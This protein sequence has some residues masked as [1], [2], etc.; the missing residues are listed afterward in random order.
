MLTVIG[1]LHL[2]PAADVD[3]PAH[4]AG[5][6]DE[7]RSASP[8]PAPGARG[9]RRS[10]EAEERV[11]VAT[12]WQLMW[13][14]FRKHKLALVVAVVAGASSTWSSSSPTSSPTPTRIASEAQR[15]LDRAAAD[16]PVRRRAAS[17]RTSRG[18]SARAIQSRSSASTC[19]TRAARCP[20]ASSSQGFE[21][22]L[23]GVIPDGPASVRRRGD[24][25]TAENSLFLLGT[26]VQGRDQ[27]SRLMYATQ[28]SL[29]IGLVS[30]A[31]SLFLGVLLGGMSGYFGG[32]ARHDHA[33]RHRDPALDPDDSALDGPGRGGA[34]RT[35][36]SL[37]VFFVMTHHLLRCSS[38]PSWRASCADAS[39]RC[40]RRTS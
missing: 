27:W 39:C 31:M 25:K 2:G 12:Q 17:A 7:R 14:R 1:T 18:W 29:L 35:G 20:S 16:P 5:G 32:T 40:A 33:A 26:D 3:R 23:F 15:S 28:V 10:T 9:G 36:T 21:Y 4:P 8:R 19:P 24:D 11:S 37:Q 38:G 13:W 34:R 6:L 22:K 30:V